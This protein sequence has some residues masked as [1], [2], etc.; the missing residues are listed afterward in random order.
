MSDVTPIRADVKIS[1]KRAP[2]DRDASIR[3]RVTDLGFRVARAA[4]LSRAMALALEG[5][6]LEFGIEAPDG[7]L[8]IADLLDGIRDEMW[9]MS[10]E[11]RTVSAPEKS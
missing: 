4:A 10:E 8:G 5:Q 2:R 9:R 7:C 11:G 3:K 6:V 1:K